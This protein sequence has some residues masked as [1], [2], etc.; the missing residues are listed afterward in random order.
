MRLWCDS[1][2]YRRSKAYHAKSKMR[3]M[4]DALQ[5][6]SGNP[7]R[8]KVIEVILTCIEGCDIGL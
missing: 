5:N 8:H 3:Y 1:Y 6:G 2:N 4:L 7:Y